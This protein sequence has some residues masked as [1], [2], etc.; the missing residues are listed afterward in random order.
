MFV[1]S[2]DPNIGQK[3]SKMKP[4]KRMIMTEYFLIKEYP[5]SENYNIVRTITQRL[6]YTLDRNRSNAFVRKVIR[7]F[8]R[9]L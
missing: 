7:D 9:E 6:N 1:N 4:S 8:F 3:I 2:L 5:G